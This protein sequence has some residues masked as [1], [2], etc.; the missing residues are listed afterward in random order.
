[1]K[2]MAA[3]ECYESEMKRIGLQV[4][5]QTTAGDMA[6]QMDLLPCLVVVFFQSMIMIHKLE[7]FIQ[8]LLISH[9]S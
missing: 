3:L 6:V 1:S 4:Q 7:V 2:K 5:Y 8:F 9:F